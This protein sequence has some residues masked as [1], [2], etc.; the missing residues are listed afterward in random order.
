ME[1]GEGEK[2]RLHNFYP[3]TIPDNITGLVILKESMMDVNTYTL[4]DHSRN[5]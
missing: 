5:R 1:N 4:K 2:N 3:N